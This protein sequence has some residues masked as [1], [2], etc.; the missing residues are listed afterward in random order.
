LNTAGLRQQETQPESAGL[1]SSQQFKGYPM[2]ELPYQT[3]PSINSVYIGAD[4]MITQAK[5]D[6]TGRA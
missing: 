3:F 2:R 6:L 1:G 5:A 4:A